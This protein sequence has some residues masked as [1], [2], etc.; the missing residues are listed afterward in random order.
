[1]VNTVYYYFYLNLI[2]KR[3]DRHQITIQRFKKTF[4][5]TEGTIK[6]RQSRDTGSIG[7]KTQNKDTKNTVSHKD[8][9][10]GPPA[11]QMKSVSITTKVVSSN[12][13][14]LRC[15]RYNFMR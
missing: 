3:R 10:H 6:S 12:P 5:K 11:P 13:A 15:T 2:L 1:L 9:Q 7:H 4:E 8:E 14:Q